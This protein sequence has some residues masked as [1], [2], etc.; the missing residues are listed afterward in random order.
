MEFCSSFGE[1]NSGISGLGLAL[2]LGGARQGSSAFL[3]VIV[4]F[5][6]SSQADLRF[7]LKVFKFWWLVFFC[8]SNHLLHNKIVETKCYTLWLLQQLISLATLSRV[9]FYHSCNSESGFNALCKVKS[10]F[11][12]AAT[13]QEDQTMATTKGDV[14]HLPIYDLDPKLKKFNDHFSYRMKR[15]L[16]QKGSLEENEGSLDEFSKG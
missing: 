3:P 7:Q 2:D 12:T 5:I 14:N 16:D 11:A 4:D 6:L 15:Y 10:K 13:V 9:S 8:H 1:K